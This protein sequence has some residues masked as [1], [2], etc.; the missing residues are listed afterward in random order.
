[1]TRKLAE[2]NGINTRDLGMR[3]LQYWLS[4]DEPNPEGMVTKKLQAKGQCRWNYPYIFSTE[5]NQRGVYTANARMT[6]EQR[7]ENAHLGGRFGNCVSYHLHRPRI[8]GLCTECATKER[9]ET[10]AYNSA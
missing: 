8:D 10:R 6:L 3:V 2:R 1:M 7:R 4:G 5:D 9:G